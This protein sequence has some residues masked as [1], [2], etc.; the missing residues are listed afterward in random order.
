MGKPMKTPAI[1]DIEGPG[2]ELTGPRGLLTIK[3]VQRLA[4]VS[5]TTVWMECQRGRLKPVR[6]GSLVR[7]E[8]A[9][10]KKWIE[11]IK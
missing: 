3:D 11:G 4:G 10:Y 5:R 2:S 7:F 1:T 8:Y 6:I 9:D